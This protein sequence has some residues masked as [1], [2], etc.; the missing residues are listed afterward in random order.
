MATVREK[1]ALPMKRARHTLA[2][3][4]APISEYR[5][6]CPRDPRN[7]TSFTRRHHKAR[8]ARR[9][10][11]DVTGGVSPPPA[12][13]RGGG[14]GAG[15]APSIVQPSRR[16]ESRGVFIHDPDW[17]IR[18]SIHMSTSVLVSD[19]REPHSAPVDPH[20]ERRLRSM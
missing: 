11:P 4:P 14:A 19:L 1:P 16:C 3:P 6:Y 20:A 17:K 8:R 15:R 5:R 12:A 18:A 7:T 13:I 9:E 2:M 10:S